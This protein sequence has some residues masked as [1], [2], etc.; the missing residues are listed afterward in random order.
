MYPLGLKNAKSKAVTGL[1][2]IAPDLPVDWDASYPGHKTTVEAACNR[3][4]ADCA[5]CAVLRQAMQH[6]VEPLDSSD[7]ITIRADSEKLLVGTVGHPSDYRRD[8]TRLEIFSAIGSPTRWPVI[9]AARDLTHYIPSESMGLAKTWLEECISQHATCS[10]ESN[11]LPTRVIDVD[12]VDT[13]PRLVTTNEVDK[14]AYVALSYCWGGAS[15]FITTTLTLKQSESGVKY[16]DLPKTIQ[17]AVTVTRTLGIQYLWVDSLCIIQDDREDWEKEAAKMKSVYANAKVTIAAD[18]AEDSQGGCFS[19]SPGKQALKIKCPGNNNDGGVDDSSYAYARLS[20]YRNEFQG[21]VSHN[22]RRDSKRYT[23][24]RLQTRG[25]TFQERLLSSRIVH[26]TASEMAWECL[27]HYRCECKLE[28]T[29]TQGGYKARIIRNLHQESQTETKSTAITKPTMSGR[30]DWRDVVIDYTFR[31][32]TVASDRLPAIGGVTELMKPNAV[33]GYAARLWK[34]DFAAHLLWYVPG[35]E[36]FVKQVSLRHATYNAPS[37]S[38]A[39]VTGPIRY[40]LPLTRPALDHYNIS[41]EVLQVEVELSGPTPFGKIKGG[42]VVLRGLVAPVAVRTF[43][44]EIDA[45]HPFGQMVHVS[46][47]SGEWNPADLQV[48]GDVCLDV[49]GGDGKDKDGKMHW[50]GLRKL[51]FE[52]NMHDELFVLMVMHRSQGY[53]DQVHFLLLKQD[54]SQQGAYQRVGYLGGPQ[55]QNWQMCSTPKA[56]V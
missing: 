6:F 41:V 51:G 39:S 14:G 12:S 15:P 24:S 32:L 53:Y 18:R 33:Q 42:Y 54:W 23:P 22:V 55:V 35:C 17:D 49:K 2:S 8:G 36:N 10:P 37:W 3:A 48:K 52:I 4:A 26:F 44:R 16:D 27:E 13:D 11:V 19:S 29:P 34:E 43:A 21:E 7:T 45:G 9:R 56:L 1:G 50:D 38:W 20:G 46:I 28:S 31:N 47:D 5:S 40:F 25:W 30:F